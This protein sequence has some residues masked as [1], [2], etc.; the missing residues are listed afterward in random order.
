MDKNT[1]IGLLL[2]GLVIVGFYWLNKPSEAE[3]AEHQR[4]LDSIAA[5]EQTQQRRDIAAGDVDTLS[6]DEL[7]ARE[8]A[9]RQRCD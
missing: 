1:L 4:Q 3:L 9:C 6:V 5:A 8:H 7:R 2:M